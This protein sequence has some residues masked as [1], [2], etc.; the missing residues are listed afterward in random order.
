M[1][2]PG[3]ITQSRLFLIVLA[4]AT[5]LGAGFRIYR[6]GAESLWLDEAV[7]IETARESPA[8]V[9]HETARDVHP[10]L[11]Y[12]TLH[13]WRGL[14]GDS[15][16]AARFLSV[17]FGVAAIPLTYKLAS[18]LFDRVTGIFSAMLLAWSHF[19]IEFSQEARMYS[20][21]ALLSLASLYFF[22]RLL[23][24][25]ATALDL[26]GY[27]VCSSLLTYT[28]VYAFFIIIAENLFVLFLFF[29]SRD[30]FRRL[31]RR[32]LLMQATL[33]LL[34]VPW[35][36]VLMRQISEHKNFWIRPPTFFELR[37]TFLQ[38]AGSYELLFV[39]APLAALPVVCL[40]AEKLS[41]G[42]ADTNETSDT[43]SLSSEFPL[44]RNE[45][46]GFLILWLAC[47]VLLPFIA[48]YFVTP[49]FLAKY[50]I[51]A[52]PAFIV[53]AARGLRMFS[54]RW[55]SIGLLILVVIL[56][57]YDLFAYWRTPRKDRW[58]DA[59]A[60]FN[61][62]ARANDLVIFSDPSGE[63]PFD[64]YAS[65]GGLIEKPFPDYNQQLTADN[66][67]ALLRPVLD[68]H[69]RVWLV[70]SH[71]GELGPLIPKQVSEWYDLLAHHTEPGVE[72]YL[73]QK[74]E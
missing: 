25:K 19:N 45:R 38:F 22:L 58:R 23:R 8:G 47:P 34:F 3:G 11:Y 51:A 65:R 27:V 20:L 60:F 48:S 16:F 61:Q 35:V 9:I 40:I 29:S 26:A 42:H 17:I 37:Y 62:T 67:A 7:S 31:I 5:A 33:L 66:V 46:I 36:T 2:S 44:T 59:V 1:A 18:L 69:E 28:Q 50:T 55:A 10:P 71:Q 30:L 24:N 52:S 6:L 73:F 14:V 63:A 21:L 72:M 54:W 43:K 68:K 56:A 12:F 74:K 13:C 53:L 4:L 15:E 41:R 32:W 57:Q 70:L 39:L 64:Y 49:F